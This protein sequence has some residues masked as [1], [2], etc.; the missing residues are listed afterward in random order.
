MARPK[1]REGRYERIALDVREDL[2]SWVDRLPES[3]REAIEEALIDLKEKKESEQMAT[4][5]TLSATL[6]Q[7]L[8]SPDFKAGVISSTKASWSGS[9]YKVEL[10]PAGDWRVLWS[11]EIGN[12]YISEGKILTLPALDTDDMG[13]YVEG[14]A[15]DED[16]FLSEAFYAEE[17]E[18]AEQMR[19][20]LS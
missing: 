17:A 14:G 16:D 11:N 20:A 9:S 19:E 18:L 12:R 10:F 13:Q 2:L 8:A 4:I 15:G 7:F 3:R 6:E 1:S 5:T